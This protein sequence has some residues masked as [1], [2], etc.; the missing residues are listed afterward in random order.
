[1]RT[2]SSNGVSQFVYT[3]AFTL[4]DSNN[5]DFLS[6]DG[7]FSGVILSG[8]DFEGVSSDLKDEVREND[9][10]LIFLQ[11][12]S[13]RVICES[14]CFCL[15]KTFQQEA[16][17]SDPISFAC[18]QVAAKE[19]PAKLA[20]K[21]YIY[22]MVLTNCRYDICVPIDK[23]SYNIRYDFHSSSIHVLCL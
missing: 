21:Q 12:E 20:E 3:F 10:L 14:A 5:D 15:P 11:L 17:T 8:V 23:K 1:M 4:G 2:S 16:L 22:N 13:N 18:A 6:V 19:L 7:V 9:S